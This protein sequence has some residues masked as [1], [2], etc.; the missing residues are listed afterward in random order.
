MLSRICARMVLTF[1]GPLRPFASLPQ[2]LDSLGLILRNVRVSQPSVATREE[3]EE[4]GI[5]IWDSAFK[6]LH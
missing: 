3:N 4:A 6:S 5:K 2:E 1:P